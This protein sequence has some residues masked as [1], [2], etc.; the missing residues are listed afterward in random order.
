MTETKITKS[1]S[2]INNLSLNIYSIG[3]SPTESSAGGALLCIGNHLSEIEIKSTF[4][5]F[6]TSK[7]SK[8]IIGTLYRYPQMDV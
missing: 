5:D 2:L 1:T 3:S 8:I 7:K 4:I 6:I